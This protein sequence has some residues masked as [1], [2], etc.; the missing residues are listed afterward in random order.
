MPD[1]GF[2]FVSTR[3]APYI[4]AVSFSP[5]PLKMSPAKWEQYSSD[6]SEYAEEIPVSLQLSTYCD[7]CI[8]TEELDSQTQTEK[9]E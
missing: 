1:P 5:K 9:N 2:N 4:F 6:D 3:R 7:S 8:L